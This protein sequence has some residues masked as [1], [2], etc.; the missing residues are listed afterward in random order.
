M[1]TSLWIV[2]A[3]LLMSAGVSSWAYEINGKWSASRAPA[4]YKINT[5]RMHDVDLVRQAA[6]I[7]GKRPAKINFSFEYAGTTSYYGA[8]PDDQCTVYMDRGEMGWGTLGL[9]WTWYS[10]G[11]ID[12]FDIALNGKIDWSDRRFLNTTIHEFGHGLG[13]DHSRDSRAVMNASGGSGDYLGDLAPDDIAGAAYLYPAPGLPLPAIPRIV[14]PDGATLPTLR[15]ALHWKSAKNATS[16]DVAVDKVDEWGEQTKLLRV[17]VKGLHW[18]PEDELDDEQDYLW[19]VRGVNEHGKSEWNDGG[20]F[21][22][23]R[24]TPAEPVLVGPV[25]STGKLRPTFRWKSV[26]SATTYEL[27]LERVGE[28]G[29]LMHASGLTA[30]SHTAPDPLEPE[31]RYRWWVRGVNE[32]GKGPWAKEEFLLTVLPGVP[33]PLD[34]SGETDESRPKFR[35]SEAANVTTYDLRIHRDG[36]VALLVE[37]L[38]KESHRLD[39]ALTYG[40]YEW[41]IRGRGESGSGSWSDLLPLVL[42]AAPPGEPEAISPLGSTTEKQPT[43]RWSAVPGATRY[44]LWVNQV[45]GEKKVVYSDQITK[46]HYTALKPIPGGDYEWYVRAY[47]GDTPGDWS[48]SEFSLPTPSAPRAIAPLGKISE[49]RPTFSWGAV[50]GATHY[51]L[52]VNEASGARK[53]IHDGKISGTS[54]TSAVSLSSL[55]RYHWWVRAWVGETAGK[56]RSSEFKLRLWSK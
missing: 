32:E 15:P 56:W 48:V 35:W 9:C 34:P 6:E 19:W 2:Y 51:E 25:D 16:Y 8:D 40:A 11:R 53:I 52:W 38:T 7:W 50:P 39:D 44:E 29:S 46:T 21:R 43:F 45:D 26:E 18:T 10:G 33:R 24:K 5:D 36:K 12:E 42:R 28:S 47:T 54:Y 22:I 37:G 17:T 4:P 20:A 3:L 1:R 30:T 23:E 55:R 13:L 27:K 31:V 14:G 49:L 41:Q